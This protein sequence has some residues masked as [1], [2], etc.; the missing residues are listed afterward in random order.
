MTVPDVCA[1]IAGC[2]YRKW[3]EEYLGLLNDG[4]NRS[5]DRKSIKTREEID[6]GF[7]SMERRGFFSASDLYQL[8]CAVVHACSSSISDEESGSKFSPFKNMGVCVQGD[9][10]DLLASYGHTGNG[11]ME[12][13]STQEEC[14]FA[15]MVK[16]EALISLMAR[17]VCRFI[18]EDPER[19][20]ELAQNGCACHQGI[21]DFR[22]LNQANCL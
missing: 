2:D 9:A 5:A 3:C 8:R 6:S 20:H 22:P 19:D 11:F 16:L 7:E 14:A 17:G 15:C 4:E 12:Q 10:D 13:T 18:K 21:V 1:R